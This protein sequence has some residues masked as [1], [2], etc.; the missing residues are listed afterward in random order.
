MPTN[1]HIVKNM[2]ITIV[3]SAKLSGEVTSGAA[4]NVFANSLLTKTLTVASWN[5]PLLSAADCVEVV[6]ALRCCVL[7]TAI[8]QRHV[9]EAVE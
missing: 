2:A 7:D 9:V 6:R 5:T 1:A 8:E 3:A 4:V